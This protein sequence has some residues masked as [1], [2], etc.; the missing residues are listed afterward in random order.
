M[1][2]GRRKKNIPVGPK[3]GIHIQS[4]IKDVVKANI[5][6]KKRKPVANLRKI[7]PS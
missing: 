7:D 2:N 4:R 5:G 6:E 1:T 3:L